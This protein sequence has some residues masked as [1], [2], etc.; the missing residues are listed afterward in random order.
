[1]NKIDFLQKKKY[2]TYYK[3]HYLESVSRLLPK[4][5]GYTEAEKLLRASKGIENQRERKKILKSMYHIEKNKMQPTSMIDL[6]RYDEQ[7]YRSYYESI[8]KNKL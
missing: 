2:E 6:I 4:I 7:N 3:G 5:F 1:M 8:L